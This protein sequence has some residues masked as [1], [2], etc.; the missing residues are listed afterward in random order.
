MIIIC[1]RECHVLNF[2]KMDR[3]H[4]ARNN[5]ISVKLLNVELET[6]GGNFFLGAKTS[7]ALP[8]EVSTV[9]YKAIF[10]KASAPLR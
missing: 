9:K 5:Q 2:K 3:K 1:C 6:G 7:S 10:R 4:A 8:P